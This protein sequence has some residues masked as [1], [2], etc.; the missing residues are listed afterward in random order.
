[1]SARVVEL[2][3]QDVS[4]GWVRLTR[5]GGQY[6]ASRWNREAEELDEVAGDRQTCR[7]AVADWIRAD[8]LESEGCY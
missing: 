6:F 3:R 7:D 1:M 5:L 8:V 4:T 2:L